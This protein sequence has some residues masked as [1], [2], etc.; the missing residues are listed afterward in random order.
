MYKGILILGV[1]LLILVLGSNY[2]FVSAVQ[3]KTIR[4]RDRQDKIYWKAYNRIERFGEHADKTTEQ[5]AEAALDEAHREGLNKNREGVLLNYFQ[6]LRSCFLNV[7]EACEKAN[8][9]MKE[10]IS[11]PYAKPVN[12]AR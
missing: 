1:V 8:S 7:R 6:D 12:A 3:Q 2:L 5:E 11:N 9:A 4:E 10:A